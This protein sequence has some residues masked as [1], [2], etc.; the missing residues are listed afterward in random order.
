M[1]RTTSYS[2]DRD[3]ADTLAKYIVIDVDAGRILNYVAVNFNPE[4]VFD[5]D[6][7]RDWALANDFVE[8]EE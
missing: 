3:M 4:D 1:S 8:K 7:L 6:V 2:E 5:P